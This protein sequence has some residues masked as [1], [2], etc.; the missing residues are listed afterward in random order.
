[1]RGFAKAAA[2]TAVCVGAALAVAP[3]QAAVINVALSAPSGPYNLGN[4]TGNIPAN[5][6]LGYAVNTSNTYNFTFAVSPG[7]YNLHTE[8]NAFGKP[9]VNGVCCTVTIEPIQYTLWFGLPGSGTLLGTSS[10]S[11]LAVLDLANI[12][13]GNY[14]MQVL[15]SNLTKREEFLDGSITLSAAVPEPGTWALLISG[16]GLLGLAARRRRS[17]AAA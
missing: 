1:M 11:T 10:N 8:M 5:K 15:P 13:G 14:F 3:A 9:K 17:M 4:P 7:L 16:V 2:F 12:T 6:P